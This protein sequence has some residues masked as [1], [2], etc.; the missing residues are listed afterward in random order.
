MDG[1]CIA[2][3]GLVRA[4]YLV[5]SYGIGCS[6]V[7]VFQDNAV[8]LAVEEDCMTVWEHSWYA[9]LCAGDRASSYTWL[10]L[11]QTRASRHDLTGPAQSHHSRV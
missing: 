3:V 5:V 4:P 7:L 8:S 2:L 6:L 11:A 9:H 1:L 10:M